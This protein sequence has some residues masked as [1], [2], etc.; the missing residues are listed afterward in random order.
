MI[1]EP[2]VGGINMCRRRGIEPLP[3]KDAVDDGK[4]LPVLYGRLAGGKEGIDFKPVTVGEIV[5]EII[6]NVNLPESYRQS[7]TKYCTI[8]CLSKGVGITS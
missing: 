5:Q 1:R 3:W 4:E 7:I 6:K 8:Y 2:V